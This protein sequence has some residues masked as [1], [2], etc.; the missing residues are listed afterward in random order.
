MSVGIFYSS[1]IGYS[2]IIADKIS[3]ELNNAECFDIVN[4]EI[5]TIKNYRQ[6]IFGAEI[7]G[8][9]IDNDW[10]NILKELSTLECRNKEF[11]LFGCCDG[12]KYSDN[13]ADGLALIYKKLQNEKAKIVGHYYDFDYNFFDSKAFIDDG[14]M[15]GLVV[16]EENQSTLTDKRIVDWCKKL[17]YEFGG[18]N[19]SRST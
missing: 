9:E 1:S 14:V 19:E 18:K 4:I 7:W 6:I 5:K 11:A 15:M 10:K 13:F 12:D 17:K 16:D 3:K 8:D 2:K